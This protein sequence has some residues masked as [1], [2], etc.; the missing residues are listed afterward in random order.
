MRMR[1]LPDSRIVHPQGPDDLESPAGAPA[2]KLSR[3]ISRDNFSS[4]AIRFSVDGWVESRLSIPRP[5]SGLTIKR[6][7][8]V[9][10]ASAVSFGTPSAMR[11]I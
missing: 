9:G 2:P 6:G 8:V 5:D 4:A 3:P 1:W 7:A 10:W 11:E